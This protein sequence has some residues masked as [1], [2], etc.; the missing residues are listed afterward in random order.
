MNIQEATEVNSN[1]THPIFSWTVDGGEADLSIAMRADVN[2]LLTGPAD[3]AL[4]MARRIHDE[5]GWRYGP[6]VVVDCT[7]PHE[8]ERRL[9]RAFSL[10]AD[11]SPDAPLRLV[12]A[13]T[14]L[15]RE[16]GQTPA[17]LQHWLA[18]RLAELRTSRR[19]RCRVMATTSERLLD[20]VLEGSFDDRLFYRLNVIHIPLPEG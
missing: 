12:Q 1:S 3:S 7:D 6:L 14:V 9:T 15:L 13:G 18:A 16:V 5:S 19:S 2:V 17:P 8:L 10:G 11:L 4:A 20:R